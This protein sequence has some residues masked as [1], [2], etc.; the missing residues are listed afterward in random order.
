MAATSTRNGNGATKRPF[1]AA[2]QV[3]EV[4]IP[5]LVITNVRVKI[6][7]ETPLITHRF[8][9]DAI[10]AIQDGQSGAAKV[11]KEARDPAREF[12]QAIYRMPDGSCGFPAGG[13]KRAMVLAGQR[14][15]S[16]KGTE[17]MG[18]FSIPAELLQI[19]SD[20]PP[21]M[22]TDR[23]RIGMGTTSIAYR[24]YF[25][26]WSMW[27][28]LRFNERFISLAQV[29]NILGLAGFSVGLGDWRVDKKGICGQFT[30][31]ETSIQRIERKP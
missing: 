26:G 2:E 25:H 14:F 16:E 10:R 9:E 11:K 7:G 23:V 8:G 28:P 1:T 19:L 21:V 24:P 5:Q 6:V 15:A 12:E 4:V 18:A 27:V 3:T 29:I 13:V 17:L 31:D 22:G 20:K 30:V